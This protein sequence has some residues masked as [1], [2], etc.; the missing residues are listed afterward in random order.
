V[1]SPRL[2]RLD[3]YEVEL[4]TSTPGYEM[5][6]G[7]RLSSFR[8]T[9]VRVQD[10]EGRFGFGES[11]T[12]GTNYIE[13]FPAGVQ[14][15]IREIAPVALSVPLFE[16]RALL[17]AVDGAVLGHLAGKAAVD[18]ALW[19]LRGKVLG[20][21][22][23]S[24][25]GGRHRQSYPAFHAISLA[26]P[27]AMAAETEARRAD[28]YRC[29][30]LKLGQEPLTD[31]RRLEAVL[32][33][34]GGAADFVTS[35]PNAAWTVAETCRFLERIQGLDTFIEQ[36][37]PT[38]REMREVRLRSSWPVTVDEAVC[39]PS[40]LVEC[41][42]LQAADAL[43]IKIT[44]VG[45]LTRAALLR[46]VAQAAGLMLMV[47]EP[48]GSHLAT[49]AIAQLAATCGPRSLLAGSNIGAYSAVPLVTPVP[50][51][52]DGAVQIPDGAG[53]GVEVDE[54]ALG[55]PVF[56]IHAENP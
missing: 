37:C 5:S 38:L 23:S 40:D 8:T 22:V 1:T 10:S 41:L 42:H 49:A 25:L 45:G 14:A 9:V 36:T 50:A 47:D 44:R 18:V 27:E 2:T 6:R 52:R 48:M 24:L 26:A 29:W 53:L 12:L 30:Q 33:A 15:T 34:A 32:T 4:P 20:L 51:F 19:D 13:A 7:R 28:G 46:D 21:P 54:E 17:E 55:A 43:N 11:C 35:D 3:C 56:T 39:E 31:A 16:P